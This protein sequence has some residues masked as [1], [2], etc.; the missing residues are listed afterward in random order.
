MKSYA[1]LAIAAL[2]VVANSAQA[3]LVVTPLDMSDDSYVRQNRATTNYG[4]L[5][6][7]V[8]KN[9]GTSTSTRLGY[10][11]IDL[12]GLPNLT[13]PVTAATLTINF[14][15]SGIGSMADLG[16]TYNFEVYGL[17]DDG[18]DGWDEG[19]ITYNNAPAVSGNGFT[20]DAS[21]LGSFQLTGKGIGT[22]IDFSAAD[23]LAFI[24]S[25]VGVSGNQIATLMI[26]R[27]EDQVNG[28]YAH[29]FVSKEGDP[30]FDP[31]LTITQ[32]NTPAPAPGVLALFL[33]GLLGLSWKQR[34]R[35][36]SSTRLVC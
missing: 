35:S 21:L 11:K 6:Q 33:S 1:Y 29:A 25:N 9:A 31:V 34:K 15:D 2:L 36:N 16:F 27:V 23:L 20:G 32:D 8:V 30:A 26:R 3:A 18:Q 5:T 14:V 28:N 17:I 13:D 12:N 4:S 19:T 7:V 10:L 24:Q 22:Q